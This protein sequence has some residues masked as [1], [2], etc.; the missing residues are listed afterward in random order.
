MKMK[1]SKKFIRKKLHLQR[2]R[3]QDKSK[4]SKRTKKGA[5]NEIMAKSEVDDLRY[6]IQQAKARIAQLTEKFGFPTKECDSSPLLQ[7]RFFR[8]VFIFR[9]RQLYQNLPSKMVS[10]SVP[11][12]EIDFQR[13]VRLQKCLYF[14]RRLKSPTVSK[15]VISRGN[16]K[17]K[18]NFISNVEIVQ[19][20]EEIYN[21]VIDYFFISNQLVPGN[22]VLSFQILKFLFFK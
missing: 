21:F 13:P 20:I 4:S 6:K 1:K 9:K 8:N 14:Q 16:L 10:K 12:L 11:S 2:S 17:L 7:K 18:T 5:R 3:S 22:F 19:I 15:N